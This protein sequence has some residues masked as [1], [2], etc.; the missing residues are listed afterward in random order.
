[1]IDFEGNSH[2]EDAPTKLHSIF[3]AEI[4]GEQASWEIA[5][6]GSGGG[7]GEEESSV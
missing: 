2:Q 5:G 3:I 1:M 4:L 7:G 6:R